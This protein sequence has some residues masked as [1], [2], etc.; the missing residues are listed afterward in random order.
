M[1]SASETLKKAHRKHSASQPLKA[2]AR[3]AAKNDKQ[4][5][6]VVTAWQ[7]NKKGPAKKKVTPIKKAEAPP[8]KTPSKPPKKR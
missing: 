8:A 5:R 1:P 2:F 7:A 6:E 3:E 4:L